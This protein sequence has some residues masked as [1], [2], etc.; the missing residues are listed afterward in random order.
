MHDFLATV[1]WVDPADPKP[2]LE[3]LEADLRERFGSLLESDFGREVFT[4]PEGNFRLWREKPYVLRDG[5][6]VANGIMDRALILLDEN[7][8]PE[9]AVIY[10]YKTDK[11]DP[12]RPA[13]EQLME[14]YALQVERYRQA[15]SVLTGLPEERISTRLVPV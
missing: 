9:Q 3:G 10:D 14:R 1:E 4:K 15:M 5:D 7:D 8:R 13:G 11:L 6:Q 12:E 2:I